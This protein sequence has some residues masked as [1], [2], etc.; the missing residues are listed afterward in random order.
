MPNK[1][2]NTINTIAIIQV[3]LAVF[4]SLNKNDK[5][6]DKG[7]EKKGNTAAITPITK[8]TGIENS[9]N[10]KL[11]GEVNA[12]II[13]TIPNAI[14]KPAP[15]KTLPKKPK[16]PAVNKLKPIT[17]SF[18]KSMTVAKAPCPQELFFNK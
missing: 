2:D 15:I 12:I 7:K 14:A 5:T 8:N 1:E 9:F 3:K 10:N 13:Q 6:N 16:N 11:A 18:I 4:E 17:E